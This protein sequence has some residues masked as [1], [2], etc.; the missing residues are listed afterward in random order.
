[1]CF[2]TK[3]IHLEAVSRLDSESCKAAMQRFVH[4]R[5]T[6]LGFFSDNGSNFKGARNELVKLETILGKSSTRDSMKGMALD[7]GSSWKNIPP[8]SPHWGGLWEAGVKLAKTHLKKVIGKNILS[9]EEFSTVLAEVEGMLNSRPLVPITDDPHDLRAISPGMLL[10]SKEMKC[11]PTRNPGVL[12][13]VMPKVGPKAIDVQ[14]RWRYL[15]NVVST[16]WRRWTKEYLPT[17]QVRTKWVKEVDDLKVDDMVLVTDERVSPSN[18]PLARVIKVWPGNDRRVRLA[19][20][21]MA[22]ADGV[23]EYNR[24]IVKLRKI[25]FG[26]EVENVTQSVNA[27][28]CSSFVQVESFLRKKTQSGE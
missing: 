14:R 24:P 19:T 25:P 15:Q 12:H 4:R 6:P 21:R 13:D 23:H 22:K 9:F 5:G 2:A 27:L 17:L 7:I 26:L 20:I 1:M 18:W 28:A 11:F 3:A 8:A 16:F 10:A